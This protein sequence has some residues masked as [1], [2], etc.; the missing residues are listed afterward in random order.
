MR[1]TW[2]VTL[3]ALAFLSGGARATESFGFFFAFGA[4]G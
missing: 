2:I 1:A 3:A 4:C